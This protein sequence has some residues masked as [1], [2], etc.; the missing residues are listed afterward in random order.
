MTMSKYPTAVQ[1]VHFGANINLC[2]TWRNLRSTMTLCS[3]RDRSVICLL[4]SLDLA[5]Q[6]F[7]MWNCFSQAI[8]KLNSWLPLELRYCKTNIGLSLCWVI[9]R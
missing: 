6:F 2:Q 1:V 9:F 3:T 5:K 7:E 4:D 8:I